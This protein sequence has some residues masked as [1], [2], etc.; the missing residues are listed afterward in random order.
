MST[1]SKGDPP[2]AHH[3]IPLKRYVTWSPGVFLAKAC[4]KS[5]PLSLYFKITLHPVSVSFT[6]LLASTNGFRLK[7]IRKKTLQTA[8]GGFKISQMRRLTFHLTY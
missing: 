2:V 8:H 1:H 3:G 5:F 6:K 7:V 4:T